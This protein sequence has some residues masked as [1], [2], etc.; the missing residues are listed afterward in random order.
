M[1]PLSIVLVAGVVLAAACQ[2]PAEEP[3]AVQDDAGSAP[4]LQSFQVR[5]GDATLVFQYAAP[6]TGKLEVARKVADVPEQA[7]GNVIV[8]STA[9]RKGDVPANL[10]IVA[11]LSEASSDGTYPYRLVSR[12]DRVRPTGSTQGPGP[13]GGTSGPSAT[14]SDKVLLFSTSWCPHCRTARQWLQ[15]NG[16]PFEEKDVE[17]DPS[18]QSLLV[19]LGRKQGLSE[20]MLSS[21]PILYVKGQL[22]LGFNQAEVARLLGR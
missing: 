10:M 21:V 6:G 15:A 4:V 14:A 1:R 19:E 20:N 17:S 13:A 9:L 18:A 12:Y 5:D 11:N 16:V 2:K 22:I 8:L 3:S 7:R